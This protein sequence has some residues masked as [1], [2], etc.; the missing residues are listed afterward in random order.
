LCG[1][2]LVEYRREP[3][4]VQPSLL[5]DEPPGLRC[6]PRNPSHDV[7]A[8]FMPHGTLLEEACKVAE[9]LG[10]PS[11]WLHEQRAFTSPGKK[12]PVNAGCSII[13]HGA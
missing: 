13:R 7:D 10:L 4:G 9:D 1:K 11:W 12:T 5:R 3:D 6:C 8:V 2:L